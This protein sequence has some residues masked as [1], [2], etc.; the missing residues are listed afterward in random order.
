MHGNTELKRFTNSGCFNTRANATPERRV[1]QHHIDGRVENVS[2]QLFEIDYDGVRRER[3]ANLFTHTPH[4]IQTIHGIFKIII[5]NVFNLLTKPD[6]SLRGPEGVRIK[7]K[8]IAIEYSGKCTI[9][10]ELIFRRK[11]SSF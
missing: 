11:N 5:A 7:A 2:R 8:A 10:F 3:H 4:S 6:R 1:Q 9:A